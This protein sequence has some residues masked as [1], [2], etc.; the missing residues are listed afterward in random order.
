MD[1]MLPTAEYRKPYKPIATL[2]TFTYE[3]TCVL[4]AV[5]VYTYVTSI[6]LFSLPELGT[7]LVHLFDEMMEYEVVSLFCD[8]VALL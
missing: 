1:E 7:A 2:Q 3:I 6:A 5:N 4:C 8:M